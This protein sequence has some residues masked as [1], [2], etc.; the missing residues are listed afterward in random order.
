MKASAS[1]RAAGDDGLSINLYKTFSETL[2][3]KFC[4]VFMEASQSGLLPESVSSS[5][6][7]V[8]PKYNEDLMQCEGC[9]PISPVNRKGKIYEEIQ[10]TR[11]HQVLPKLIHRDQTAFIR[12]RQ[13]TDSL[14]KLMHL[15]P[16]LLKVCVYKNVCKLIAHAK[17]RTY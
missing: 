4:K 3:D 1:G 2:S 7:K 16:D 15:G 17:K 14:R 11:L 10:T 6:I 12:T 13:I 9:R 5:L 8:L